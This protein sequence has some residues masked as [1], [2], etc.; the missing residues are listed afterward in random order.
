MKTLA[1]GLRRKLYLSLSLAASAVLAGT[2]MLQ[3]AQSGTAS[4]AA[5]ISAEISSSQMS[6]L[7]NSKHPLALAQYDSGRL[8]SAT[9]LQGI[10]I[11][12]SRTVSQEADLQ[13]LMAAQQNPASPQYHQWLTPDQF[14]SRFGVA[15]ADIAKVET[16]LQQQG[17]SIDSVARS[18]NMIRFSGT[19]AQAEAAFA[20]ELH[21][22]TVNGVKHFA[23]STNLSVPTA[24][25]GVVQ[26]VR[27]LDDFKPKSHLKITPMSL[28][29]KY[30]DGSGDHELTPADIYT[31]Y[32]ITPL[33]NSGITG[34]GQTIA[35]VG[36]SDVSLTDIAN[37]RS[38]AGLTASTPTKILVPGS[39]AP[40]FSSGDEVESDLDLEWSGAIA[41]AASIDFVYTGD[42]SNSSA[43]DAIIYAIDQRIA[44]IISSSYGDCEL[45]LGGSTLETNFEQAAAQG[46][47]VLSAAGD[48]GS[49]DC[50]P[51]T[52]LSLAEQ[53]SVAV[54]YP[55]SSPNVTGVGGTEFSGDTSS[56][57]SYW[58]STNGTGG[59]SATAYIPETTWNDDSTCK[60]DASSPL[61]ATGGGASVLFSKPSWQAGTGVPAD[62][63][64]DVP[65]VALDASN[66]HDPY[67]FCSGDLA[68]TGVSGSC[69]SGFLDST[70]KNLTAA[71][72]TSFA[73]PIFAGILALINQ[74]QNSTGQGLINS[75]LYTMAASSTVYSSAFHDIT[76]GNNDCT[77]G[78]TY[79]LATTGYS[80]GTG[81]DQVTGLGTVDANNLA[82]NWPTTASGT[83]PALA[84]S[85]TTVTAS[86][87]T[88][89]LSAADTFTITVA[90]TSGSG[91]PTGTVSVSLDG[92]VVSTPAL[93]NGSATYSATF[94]TAG[95]HVLSVSY[96]GDSTYAASVASASVNV[97]SNAGSF[98]F[99]AATSSITITSSTVCSNSSLDGNGY[100]TYCDVLTVTPANGYT[101]TID[102][103]ATTTD[104]TLASEGCWNWDP[105]T[106]SGTSTASGTIYIS[107]NSSFCSSNGL[108]ITGS[109]RPNHRFK[110]V[111][112]TTA[113]IQ[114]SGRFTSQAGLWSIGLLLAAIV[115]FRVRKLRGFAMLLFA[116]A[117]GL[118]M[119][120]CGGGSSSS[121]TTSTGGSTGVSVV[122]TGTDTVSP[123]ITSTATL[124]VI[125]Q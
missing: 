112:K 44:P 2:P 63:A 114:Q 3:A 19:S 62:G 108:A 55:A 124:S 22:Y 17:F 20:T 9:R 4:P 98:S 77:A 52:S 106:V 110:L 89:A 116:V 12:F 67:L 18:K 15:D 51:D 84:G 96:S 117:L 37:F 47:T 118:G 97:L 94:T 123:S 69:S 74:K 92:T 48:D 39:G 27:N 65:D 29:P 7:P 32:D 83:E 13:A 60:S 30:T 21:Y 40:F 11:S 113:Q 71:G 38:A 125:V 64:R 73:T 26:G 25:A 41:K 56:S 66:V 111:P 16:W 87:T 121:G 42:G 76:T 46:Q 61:C 50:F 115:G 107:V 53:G 43:F 10:S 5:R 57:S 58:G 54:D 23:P 119:S 81:Y 75:T 28:R 99:T 120:A 34:D 100:D 35:I 72:G 101:G 70:G 24:L 103:Q 78:S 122:V 86:S 90:P 33:Y 14:A 102:F 79:C 8:P 104:A 6:V 68:S 85:T 82:T 109:H 31:I 88:P 59:G 45:D 80:A 91:T 49:N 1:P 105:A 36:Q 93:S 95:N